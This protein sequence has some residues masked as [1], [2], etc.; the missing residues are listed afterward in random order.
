V[1][2]GSLA[3]RVHAAIS[4]G[5]EL[6]STL[7][8]AVYR[9]SKSSRNSWRRFESRPLRCTN[10]A[11]V[12]TFLLRVTGFRYP[13]AYPL[14][15]VRGEQVDLQLRQRNA[16]QRR[17]EWATCFTREPWEHPSSRRRATGDTSGTVDTDTLGVQRPGYLSIRLPMR[18]SSLRMVSGSMSESSG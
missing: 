1:T 12:T 10:V 15:P 6:G 16:C 18:G 2:L 3:E 17:C 7:R 5:Q 9:A 8:L 13:I 4:R 14:A 11:K